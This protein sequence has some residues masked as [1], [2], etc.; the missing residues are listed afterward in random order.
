MAAAN[1]VGMTEV[2]EAS[3]TSQNVLFVSHPGD[4][5]LFG[6]VD[7]DQKGYFSYRDFLNKM[8]WQDSNESR[9]HFDRY[10]APPL[11]V[12]CNDAKHR[13]CD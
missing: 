13:Y 4:S 7:R 12:S 9:L 11:A 8:E 6:E 3:Q 5:Q 1:G 10:V 2:V